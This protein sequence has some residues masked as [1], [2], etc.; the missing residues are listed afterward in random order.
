MSRHGSEFHIRSWLLLCA[1]FWGTGCVGE[2]ESTQ[3][4]GP[5]NQDPY[6]MPESSGTGGGTPTPGS[7]LPPGPSGLGDMGGSWRDD[8]GGMA[9]GD[10]M[11]SPPPAAFGS[12]PP[13]EYARKVKF[14]VHG[15]ALT[16][17]EL[18]Q[19][20]MESKGLRSLLTQWVE[21]PQFR[22][23]IFLF[24]RDSL[25]QEYRP[26]AAD[27][28]SAIVT[29]I[30]GADEDGRFR[31]SDRFHQSIEDMFI[32][33][34]L[35]I[36]DDGRPFHEIATT[37]TWV[38][39]TAIA[40]YLLAADQVPQKG[41]DLDIH[42][43]Y[44][45]KSG[46]AG[47]DANTPLSKQI[48]HMTWYLPEY[49]EDFKSRSECGKTLERKGRAVGLSELWIGTRC[50]EGGKAAGIELEDFTQW[51][52]VTIR[53]LGQKTRL[54]YY[55]LISIRKAVHQDKTLDL[56]MPRVGFFTTP[57]YLAHWRTN[58]D[59]S[60]RVTTNQALIIGLNHSFEPEGFTLPLSQ[61][62]LGKEHVDPTTACYGCHVALDPMRNY[63]ARVFDP[64]YY[65][66]PKEKRRL[67][68]QGLVRVHGLPGGLG[69]RP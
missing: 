63:F 33:T 7:T 19:V 8:G 4:L 59:N 42:M 39:T 22:D 66:V 26:T 24:L 2:G 67:H 6:R 3:N 46:I 14:L 31:A 32:Y 1:L 51:N 45:P 27:I 21:T 11:L 20:S 30:L 54:R 69:Q 56:E 35:K 25:Q 18:D 28:N 17:G 16:A 15:G 13:E 9:G 53:P 36:I 48:D 10:D 57:A 47:F 37:N 23:K 29:Q 41:D 64:D 49:E 61:E 62:G 38:M 5:N 60:F 65:S 50:A 44:G 40:M 55:D 58:A 12:L 52:E 43:F 68:G 34:A